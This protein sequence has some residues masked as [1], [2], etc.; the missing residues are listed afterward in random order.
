MAHSKDN[1]RYL[2]V[3]NMIN[4]KCKFCNI[5]FSVHNYRQNIV[6]FCSRKCKYNNQK[7]EKSGNNNHQWKKKIE[8]NCVVCNKIFLICPSRLDR[9]K[10]CSKICHGKNTIAKSC[11]GENNPNW[12]GGRS[13]RAKKLRNCKKYKEWRTNIFQRD[14]YTC[15]MCSKRGSYLEAH[16]IIKFAD[17]LNKEENKIFDIDNGITLC[18]KCHNTVK[19]KEQSYIV[20]F[21]NIINKGNKCLIHLKD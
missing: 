5:E 16:H 19:R 3:I 2:L 4:T 1:H 9:A 17:C 11:N 7:V 6:K 21:T 14:D 20:L 15:Q 10:Y 18:K 8:L 12:K 13:T